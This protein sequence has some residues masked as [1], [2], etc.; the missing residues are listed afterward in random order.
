MIKYLSLSGVLFVLFFSVACAQSGTKEAQSNSESIYQDLDAAQFLEKMKGPN[1]VILDVRTPGEVAQGNIEG[2]VHIDY[3]AGD[4]TT[5][6]DALDKS[7]E[8]YV[9][10]ASGGRSAKAGKMMQK[11]GFKNVSNLLGGYSSWPY[12]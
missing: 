5:K 9:Y 12:K 1:T 2:H 4:F 6:I 7:K 10:C 3:R 11:S 8:Y